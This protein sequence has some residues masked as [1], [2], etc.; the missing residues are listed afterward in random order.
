MDIISFSLHLQPYYEVR[1]GIIPIPDEELR[2]FEW[3]QI[4]Q[5]SQLIRGT[6]GV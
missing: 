3:K 5:A 4:D 2:A 1:G 6:T